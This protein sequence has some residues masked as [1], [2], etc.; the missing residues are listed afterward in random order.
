MAVLPSVYEY[1]SQYIL[2][3]YLIFIDFFLSICCIN[4]SVIATD[5][6][7][8]TTMVVNCGEDDKLMVALCNASFIPYISHTCGVSRLSLPYSPFSIKCSNS[9]TRAKLPALVCDFIE[10]VSLWLIRTWIN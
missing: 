8:S 1:S 6:D 7:L 10:N 9:Q 4:S 2:K 3:D 5:W